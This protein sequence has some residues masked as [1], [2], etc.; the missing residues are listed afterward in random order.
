MGFLGGETSLGS[1]VIH[2]LC[3]CVCSTPS[4][5]SRISGEMLLWE[6]ICIWACPLVVARE[7]S[8]CPNKHLW[9]SLPLGKSISFP[10][11]C[12]VTVLGNVAWN[13]KSFIANVCCLLTRVLKSWHWSAISTKGS[14]AIYILHYI[15][16]E[17]EF[18]FTVKKFN[19]L[20]AGQNIHLIVRFL[21]LNHEMGYFAEMYPDAW[22]LH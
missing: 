5:K 10:L 13:D 21:F 14:S 11:S 8:L 2:L 1:G 17:Q 6:N 12:L 22:N 20:P 15:Q 19:S 3:S 18:F 4:R 16:S 7:A 9:T